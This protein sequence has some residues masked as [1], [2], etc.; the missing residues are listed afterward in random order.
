M[1]KV[2]NLKSCQLVFQAVIHQVVNRLVA[3]QSSLDFN[4]GK[5]VTLSVCWSD[6][7]VDSG[8]DVAQSVS[9]SDP[10]STELSRLIRLMK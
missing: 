7:R 4:F 3:S 2:Q 8:S 6:S 9:F 5:P 1:D 10:V